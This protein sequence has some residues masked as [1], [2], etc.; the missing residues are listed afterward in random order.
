ME[1]ISLSDTSAVACSKA[2][3]HLDFTFW[4]AQNNHFRLWAVIY[5]L[6][7]TVPGSS[8]NSWDSRF[9]FNLRKNKHLLLHDTLYMGKFK[10]T[11]YCYK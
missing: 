5:F 3:I 2:W 10:R 1:A 11:F 6:F 8:I 7:A 9:I 4:C